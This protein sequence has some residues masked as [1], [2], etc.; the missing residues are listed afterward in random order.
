MA[1]TNT[2]S[3]EKTDIKFV[4]N[5]KYGTIGIGSNGWTKEVCNITWND[6]SP[7][8]DIREW[9]SEYIKMSKG[10]TF[11]KEEAKKLLKIMASIN[12]EEFDSYMDNGSKIRQI[13]NIINNKSYNIENYPADNF[14]KVA[15]TNEQKSEEQNGREQSVPGQSVSGQNEQDS[16][17]QINIDPE[18]KDREELDEELEEHFQ[19]EQEEEEM[20]YRASKMF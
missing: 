10:L 16:G 2:R 1:N 5:R 8:L 19:R 13:G 4:R 6:R 11:S 17:R 14:S 12:F 15:E 9:D 7:K 20:K 3:R 18:Q